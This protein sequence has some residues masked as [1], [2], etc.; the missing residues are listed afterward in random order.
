MNGCQFSSHRRATPS[1]QVVRNR[2]EFGA[3]AAE[4]TLPGGNRTTVPVTHVETQAGS[5][6]TVM[7]R[8]E[9]MQ[10]VM[11][12]P[13][14][15]VPRLRLSV[16]NLVFQGPVVRAALRTIEGTEVI[17]QIGPEDDL[18]MLRPGAEVW[19]TWDADAARLLPAYDKKFT[20]QSEIDELA[21]LGATR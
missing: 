17:A 18:P 15:N 1:R 3:K 11:D 2:F 19:A 8:P 21:T 5:D 10:V 16:A 20:E 13:D 9:R 14:G 6:G 4:V 12:E 7:V